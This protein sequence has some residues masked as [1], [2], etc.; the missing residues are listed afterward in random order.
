MLPYY[1]PSSGVCACVC[2]CQKRQ[3]YLAQ[4]GVMNSPQWLDGSEPH[5]TRSPTDPSV[6]ES[7]GPG[8]VFSWGSIKRQ[9][10][11]FCCFFMRHH[12]CLDHTTYTHTH[13]C[14]Q[15]L[16]IWSGFTP[17]T[18]KID[19]SISLWSIQSVLL[20]SNLPTVRHVSPLKLTFFP[21]R[22][23]NMN[24]G[25]LKPHQCSK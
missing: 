6:C 8:I 15:T 19:A 10:E 23:P 2:R 24:V 20:S 21:I 22:D 7:S 14:A 25:K 3:L 11:K 13:S 1:P 4:S 9:K 18:F 16:T 17:H 5:Y 12:G